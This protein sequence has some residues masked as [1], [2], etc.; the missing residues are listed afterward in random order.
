M[1]SLFSR[2][3]T[4][5]IE[6][7]THA[8]VDIK[9]FLACPILLDFSFFVPNVVPRIVVMEQ[10]CGIV[11]MKLRKERIFNTVS[12]FNLARDAKIFPE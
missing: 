2:N 12:S 1:P 6:V 7:K 10:D 5:A 4:L 3:S 11:V 8:K 9:L